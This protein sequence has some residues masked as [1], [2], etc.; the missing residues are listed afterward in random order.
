M[1][2]KAKRIPKYSK[3]KKRTKTKIF[4]SKTR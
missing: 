4:N 3:P 1:N 2:I